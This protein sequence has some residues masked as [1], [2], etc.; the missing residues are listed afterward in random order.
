MD[1]VRTYLELRAP[2]QLRPAA[3]DGDPRVVVVRR[4]PC[5]AAHYR[6]LYRNVG[7]RYHWRDRLTWSDE[8][9]ARHL[10]RPNVELWELQVDDETAGYFELVAHDD[11]S[12]E[13]A[14]FGLIERFFGRGLGKYLLTR[15]VERAWALGATRVWLHTCTLDGAAALP[16][17]L[18]RG[19]TPYRQ[20]TYAIDLAGQ[21]RPG[22]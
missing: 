14:Y 20:E 9:L 12:V 7:E 11:R 19:F 10:A 2:D 22:A 3:H 16:N 18:A 15:A 8:E 6:A 21:K 5:P 17:Y 1:V 13:V 4:D